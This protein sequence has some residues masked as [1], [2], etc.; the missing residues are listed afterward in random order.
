MTASKLRWK[1]LGRWFALAVVPVALSG[2][3][4]RRT[5]AAVP[6]SPAAESVELFAAMKSGDIDVKLIP[7]NDRE[8]RII[9]KNNTKRP[10]TVILPDAIAGVP[11]LAQGGFPFGLNPAG[12]N[13]N[14]PGNNGNNANQVIGGGPPRPI[15]NNQRNGFFNLPP[16]KVGDFK[17]VTVCLEHGKKDPRPSVP[18]EIRPIESVVS[19]PAVQALCGMLGQEQ[20]DQRAAQAA[21]WHLANDMS[22]EELAA[23]RIEHLNA[24]NEPYFTADQLQ[25]AKNLARQ[26]VETAARHS[27]AEDGKPATSGTTGAVAAKAKPA[28]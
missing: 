28:N 13:R 24:P 23:K 2:A 16:E 26:A 25:N 6:A 9:L 8:S 12:P 19:K 27:P 5:S 7:K 20:I 11:V 22:W 1:R 18:Y 4:V 3:D 10:L 17:V 21:A 14:N 15:G